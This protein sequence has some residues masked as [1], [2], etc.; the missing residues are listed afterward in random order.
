M[1]WTDICQSLT[2]LLFHLNLEGT[3][4]IWPFSKVCNQNLQGNW[5]LSISQFYNESKIRLA[6]RLEC[7]AT[8]PEIP[9]IFVSM[10][11][12]HFE[13]LN[14]MII[15]ILLCTLRQCKSNF[16][17]HCPCYSNL[18]TANYHRKPGHTPFHMSPVLL[19]E[20]VRRD[21]AKLYDVGYQTTHHAMGQDL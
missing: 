13:N 2:T 3:V 11:C 21:N 15:I 19:D 20:I 1:S 7:T 12:L 4:S 17:Y 5:M 14:Y 18:D 9:L 8:H 10:I 6:T 16:K